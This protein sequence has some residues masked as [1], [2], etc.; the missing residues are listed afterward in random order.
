VDRLDRGPSDRS[1]W[2][3]NVVL[4]G[5]Q[6]TPLPCKCMTKRN[7]RV[8]MHSRRCSAR[9]HESETSC[10]RSHADPPTR[11]TNN[12]RTH[13]GSEHIYLTE[14]LDGC[15]DVQMDRPV[16]PRLGEVRPILDLARLAWLENW[17]GPS[18]HA[19]SIS[20]PSPARSGPKRVGPVRLA[21][22]NGLCGPVSTF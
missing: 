8:V 15:R 16:R 11:N 7:T 10:C 6:R 4:A 1:I 18:R 13:P 14:L 21:R 3:R 2:C 12:H 19:G 20:C 9:L 22:K 17:V 5:S